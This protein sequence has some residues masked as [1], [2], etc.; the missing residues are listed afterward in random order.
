MEDQSFESRIDLSPVKDSYVSI[1][2]EMEQVIAGQR[3]LIHLMILGLFSDGHLLLEGMPGVAKTLSAR[4]L[5]RV[6]N[7]NFGRIQFTPDLMPSDVLGTNIY[8]MSSGEFEFKAGPIFSNIVVVDEINRAP[9]KTQSALFECME[10]RQVTVDGTTYKLDKPFLIVATQNPVDQ[11]GTYSLPE[12]QLDRF[13][14]RIKVPYP[15]Q[16]SEIAILERSNNEDAKIDV[17]QITPI[18]SPDALTDIRKTVNQISVKPE[19]LTYITALVQETRNNPSLYLGASPR[20]SILIMKTAKATAAVNGRDFVIPEDVKEV[21]K[22]VLNHRLVLNPE[23]EM[24]GTTVDAVID[25]IVATVE[26]PR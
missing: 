10:E 24:D 16:Q 26:V 4:C 25:Q 5:S 8:N 7:T 20:A 17:E 2:N 22:P 19:L 1:F 3:S 6:V 23:K 12:A 21:V 11:E 13:M 14:F 15:D 9:A 18:L